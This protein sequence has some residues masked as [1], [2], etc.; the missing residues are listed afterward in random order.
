MDIVLSY[1]TKSSSHDTGGEAL[2]LRIKERLEATAH[3]AYPSRN[4]TTFNGMQVPPGGDWRVW[5]CSKAAKSTVVLPLLSDAFFDSDACNDELTF[6]KNH[7]K[8]LIPVIGEVVSPTGCPVNCRMMLQNA[9]SVPSASD[10]VDFE[11]D[12]E[13]HFATLLDDLHLALSKD[14]LNTTACPNVDFHSKTLVSVS[15]HQARCVTS[16]SVMLTWDSEDIEEKSRCCICT[17]V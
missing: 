14:N 2:M 11:V 1:R 8:T 16:G 12:F 15:D 13:K 5:W 10:G 6:S 4:I 3:P 7:G 9:S 17:V